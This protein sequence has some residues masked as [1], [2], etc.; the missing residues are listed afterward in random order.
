MARATL[1]P[2]MMPYNGSN[3]RSILVMDNCTIHHISD[4][5]DFLLSVGILVIYLPPYSPD[6]NPIEE[7]FSFLKYYLKQHD[8]VI[9]A[10][11]SNPIEVIKSAFN[12]ITRDHCKAWVRHAGYGN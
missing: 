7:L 1:V 9:Q 12:E 8:E 3:P 10:L 11:N 4:V 5:I 6:L 2:E